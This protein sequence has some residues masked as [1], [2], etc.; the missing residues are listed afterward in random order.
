MAYHTVDTEIDIWSQFPK[1][2]VPPSHM[3]GRPL[4]AVPLLSDTVD[5]RSDAVSDAVCHLS[6]MVTEIV[7]MWGAG[8][9]VV[10]DPRVWMGRVRGHQ[11]G[12][13]FVV[14]CGI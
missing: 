12:R 2:A 5:Q 9:Y 8:N 13:Q 10:A 3:V 1:S 4:D 14:L 7:P 11:S 6:D